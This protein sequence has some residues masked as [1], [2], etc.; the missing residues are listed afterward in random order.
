M[1]KVARRLWWWWGDRKE[2]WR[3]KGTQIQNDI[4][5]SLLI[6]MPPFVRSLLCFGKD[7]VAL[8]PTVPSTTH[9]RNLLL[10]SFFFFCY[11]RVE[12]TAQN[13]KGTI[14]NGVVWVSVGFFEKKKEIADEEEFT[15]RHIQ[16]R[17]CADDKQNAAPPPLHGTMYRLRK[18]FG[19]R[20]GESQR[21]LDQRRRRRRRKGSIGSCG[22]SG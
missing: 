17:F 6:I 7:L 9:L 2:D 11:P 21:E 15:K 4:R 12:F 20:P 3:W 14:R 10:L 5:S 13:E 8:P 22:C 19:E 18:F 1:C 16:S